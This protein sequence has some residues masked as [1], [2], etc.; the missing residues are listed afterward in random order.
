[1]KVIIYSAWVVPVV[2]TVKNKRA[3]K[4]IAKREKE[5]QK[6]VEIFTEKEYRDKDLMQVA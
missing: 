4:R 6:L 2:L 3:A 1:M 5:N